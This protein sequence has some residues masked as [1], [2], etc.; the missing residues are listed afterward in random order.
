M[1]S[2]KTELDVKGHGYAM[3]TLTYREVEGVWKWGG[4]TTLIRWNEDDFDK[5]FRFH[6]PEEQSVAALVEP[7]EI[8]AEV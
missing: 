8:A 7:K 3:I 1:T 4:I 6:P 5:V 2:E